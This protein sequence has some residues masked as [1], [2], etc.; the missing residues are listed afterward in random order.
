MSFGFAQQIV[1]F[2]CKRSGRLFWQQ[3]T[4]YNAGYEGGQDKKGD[5]ADTGRS[6]ALHSHWFNWMKAYQ[7]Q[8]TVILK[9]SLLIF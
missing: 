4:K 2:F 3:R 9:H 1:K 8:T 5:T 7:N 6:L